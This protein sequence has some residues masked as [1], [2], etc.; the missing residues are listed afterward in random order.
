MPKHPVR[1][2]TEGFRLLVSEYRIEIQDSDIV[3]QSKSC[4][5]RSAEI[6]RLCGKWLEE[7]MK[8]EDTVKI[9]EAKFFTC[10]IRPCYF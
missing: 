1:M 8:N 4:E 9:K 6:L 7:E 2:T 5:A 10:L 3:E